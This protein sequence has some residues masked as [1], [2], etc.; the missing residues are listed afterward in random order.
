MNRADAGASVPRARKS[1]AHRSTRNRQSI[2]VR[3]VALGGAAVCIGFVAEMNAPDA[4]ALSILL[5]AG[6]GNATQINILEGN[7]FN[8]QFGLGGN[9]VSHNVTIGDIIFGLGNHSS[10]GTS[11]GLFGPIALGGA[12]GNG[13]VTQINI[14]SYNIIN[15]QFSIKG[16][17]L[18]NNTT[19]SNVAVGNGNGSSSSGSGG[20]GLI[21]GAA[22]NGNTTQIAFFSGNIFNPQFSLFGDNVSNNT[23][24][25]NVSVGNGNGSDTTTSGGVFGTTLLGAVTGNGNTTQIGSF[26][27]NIINPQVS[28]WGSNSSN[29]LAAN[30][31]SLFNGN[32]SDNS[33]TSGGFLGTSLFGSTTGNGNTTQYGGVVSN[34]FNSQFSY[35]GENASTND[36]TTNASVGNG[37]FSDNEVDSTGILGNNT[38]LGGTNGNGNSDQNA[39]GAG[40]IVNNQLRLGDQIWLPGMPLPTSTQDTSAVR[41][42]LVATPGS[43]GMSTP[44]RPLGAVVSRVKDAVEKTTNAVKGALGLGGGTSTG[45]GAGGAESQSSPGD[46]SN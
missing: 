39:T 31:L 17:N 36:S 11:G 29:N 6:N 28:L 40:N 15:P 37:N 23:A 34:I 5:P 35:L 42:S 26:A 7:V 44:K 2:L 38:I 24:V 14:L 25:S 16:G 45:T 1:G 3:T 20:A 46:P 12:N 32:F 43:T 30:N 33:T 22:G 27:G 41:D 8:P 18:S 4:E 9:N 10:Q 21:G 13:N 19:V